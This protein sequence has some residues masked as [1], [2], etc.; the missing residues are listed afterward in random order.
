MC[1]KT[2]LNKCLN[3]SFDFK[4]MRGSAGL[5]VSASG[6]SAAVAQF[7]MVRVSH[8]VPFIRAFRRHRPAESSSVWR[9]TSAGGAFERFLLHF[10]PPVPPDSCHSPR[11][12][13]HCTSTRTDT[14]PNGQE[15][16]GEGGSS[17]Q[18]ALGSLSSIRRVWRVVGGAYELLTHNADLQVWSV[19]S[20]QDKW[21]K[22]QIVKID[23]IEHLKI[24]K[25]FL[26]PK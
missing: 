5:R 21:T 15:M 8:L 17:S 2:K 11:R 19:G 7:Q 16:S 18:S 13:T 4:Y 1:R 14:P 9:G 12:A 23:K 22:N 25:Q 3:E 10:C 20:N 24:W 6:T 26:T